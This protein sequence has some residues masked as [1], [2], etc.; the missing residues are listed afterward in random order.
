MRH[1]GVNIVQGE[2][3]RCPFHGEDKN[4]SATIRN[5][6]FYCFVCNEKHDVFSFIQHMERCTFAE[7]LAIGAELVGIKATQSPSK[8]RYIIAERKHDH[9]EK[10][11][12][13]ASSEFRYAILLKVSKS[14]RENN[15]SWLDRLD[16]LLDAWLCEVPLWVDMR[17]LSISLA[18]NDLTGMGFAVNRIYEEWVYRA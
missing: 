10:E 2:K 12:I 4:P 18:S 11:R 3:V 7:A 9:S 17:P 16:F 8:A 5:N 13:R 1:Y 6:F 14:V 15:P